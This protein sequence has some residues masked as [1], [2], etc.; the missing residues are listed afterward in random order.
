[1]FASLRDGVWQTKRIPA[2]GGSTEKFVDGFFR[3]DWIQKPDKPG[4]ML[5]TAMTPGLRLLDG[6]HGNVLWQDIKP[7]NGMPTFSPDGKL[8]SISYPE[9]R[10]RDAI[11]VYDVGGGTARVAVRFPHQFHMWFR[12]SWIDGGRAFLVNR[13]EV[14]SQVVL[15]DRFW[16]PA[17]GR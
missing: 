6:E 8:V 15:F 14:V 1:M 7:G 9:H 5:V 10:D 3:G 11:W 17:T 4:T 2:S 12:A 16:Q 13:G